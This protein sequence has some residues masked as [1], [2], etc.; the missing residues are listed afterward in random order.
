[1]R[2]SR[3][4]F[5]MF[6]V[7]AIGAILTAC[8]DKEKDSLLVAPSSLSFKAEE[9]QA[10]TIEVS[11]NVPNWSA[12]LDNASDSWVQIE[13]KENSLS[14]SVEK[15]DNTQQPRSATI[16]I[17]A[18][19]AE[20]KTVTITQAAMDKHQLSVSPTSLTYVENETGSKALTIDTNAP[21]WNFSGGADWMQLSKNGNSLTVTVPELN[22]G[23]SDRSADIII[24]AGNAPE[25]TVKVTQ[26]PTGDGKLKFEDV[27]TG[28]YTARS[29]ERRVGKECRSRWSPYH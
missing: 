27:P 8:S 1:M 21:S 9:T 16:N 13:K 22:N 14:V 5:S 2:Q 7:I 26:M 29:E 19:K 20:P 4:Y 28:N 3:F 6:V 17:T 18:G 15:Y 10:Q 11:T 25:V 12:A 24:T 23:T